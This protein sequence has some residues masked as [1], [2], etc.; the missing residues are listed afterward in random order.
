MCLKERDGKAGHS[1]HVTKR[2]SK[3]SGRFR[4]GV[5]SLWWHRLLQESEGRHGPLPRNTHVC[6][7]S[8]VLEHSFTTQ[9]RDF[10][11]DVFEEHEKPMSVQKY[12][13]RKEE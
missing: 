3:Q 7:Q 8:V 9:G 12:K 4:A 1:S 10:S 5:H 13:L 6:V 2:M 11:L